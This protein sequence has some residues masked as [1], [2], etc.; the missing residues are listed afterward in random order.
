MEAMKD[1]ARVKKMFAAGEITMRDPKSGYRY[2]LAA[3]CPKDGSIS[4]VKLF[5]KSGQALSRVIF[6][7]STCFDHFEARTK[8]I[9]VC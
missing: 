5:D 1:Q 8:D 3:I 4:Y 7:C 9:M 2:S 6:E